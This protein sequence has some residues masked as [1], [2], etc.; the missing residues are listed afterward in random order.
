MAEPSLNREVAELGAL[1]VVETKEKVQWGEVQ[2][3]VL[4]GYP[5]LTHAR[6]LLLR[7][8][9]APRA[10]AWLKTLLTEN[11]VRFGWGEKHHFHPSMAIAFTK[12][13]L[14]LLGL[15]A[16]T[17][18]GFSPEFV[19]GMTSLGRPRK[20]GDTG[21]SAPSEW[22][23]GTD[24]WAP[25]VLY[26]VY[27]ADEAALTE[28]VNRELTTIASSGLTV[29]TGRHGEELG[30]SRPLDDRREHFGFADGLSQPRFREEP[31]GRRSKTVLEADKIAAGELLLGYL[32]EAEI[33]PRSPVLSTE[34]A[35]RAPFPRPDGDFGQ[36]GS[37][38]VYRQLEQDVG[39]FWK[40]MG[41]L[42]ES[43]SV[44]DRVYLASKIVGRWP[45][46]APLVTKPT[47]ESPNARNP[48]AFDY[49][50]DD[51]D[52][53]KCPFGSH[54]RRSN[55]RATLARDPEMGLAKSK[56]H[57][58][59]R[60]GRPYGE[61]FVPS[62]TPADLSAA[63]D[64]NAGAP[65]SRGIH[66]LCFNADIANQFEFVQQTWTNGPIFQGLHGEVDPLVGDP[67]PSGGLYTIPCDPVRRRVHGLPRFVTVRG[68][69]YFF[70][71]SRTALLYLASIP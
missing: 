3:L 2:R 36:N 18:E 49:A 23:W 45:D 70:A 62:M 7:V 42:G 26:A 34:Q 13:G 50:H 71:P 21:E 69:A 43:G 9:D 63:A 20:F 6:F 46:G 15:D 52:G 65:G 22:L 29:L 10:R 33:F 31:G 40:A 44:E 1:P 32:N 61:P 47:P 30:K 27:A 64:A 12:E 60:R 41:T 51:A 25:H 54:I 59:L 14:S 66:F 55:P 4:S 11:R 37:Y 35:A 67:A 8:E 56:K 39:A 19:D 48:E 58:L 53:L 24:A 68:G 16:P 38:L 57:R 28:T 17:L 5:K